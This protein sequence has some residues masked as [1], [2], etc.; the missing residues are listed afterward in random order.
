[1][2]CCTN[3]FSL[4]ATAVQSCNIKPLCFII[5]MFTHKDVLK[6]SLS[7]LPSLGKLICIRIRR[8]GE[9]QKKDSDED[10]SMPRSS[11]NL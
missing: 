3:D 10:D 11:T 9:K 2:N 8:Y 1:M 5:H 4:N 7:A 6:V